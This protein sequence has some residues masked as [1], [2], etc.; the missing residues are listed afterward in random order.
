MSTIRFLVIMLLIAILGYSVSPY[1]TAPSEVSMTGK[2]FARDETRLS[3][4]KTCNEPT[5]INSAKLS[6]LL[7][8]I[9]SIRR[10]VEERGHATAY[11]Y[12]SGRAV[13]EALAFFDMMRTSGLSNKT[14][15]IATG[16]IWSASNI[17]WLAAERRVVL[18]GSQFIIHSATHNMSNESKQIREEAAEN[19]IDSTTDAVS[20]AAG[21]SG[22]N[23][24]ERSI[25][26]LGPGMALNARQ[27][28]EY[29]WATEIQGYEDA[30]QN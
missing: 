19:M 11:V 25:Q 10:C 18:P 23:L 29:G 27:A 30:P 14:T 2:E 13:D 21:K 8:V 9:N 5:I 1:P 22:A 24:W 26:A 15:F 16:V 17:I 12:G 20:L 3:T 4:E 28:L 7:P 6:D